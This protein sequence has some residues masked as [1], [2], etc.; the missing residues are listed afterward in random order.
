MQQNYNKTIAACFVSYIIQAVVNTFAPLLFVTFQQS[1]GIPLSFIT[2]L[3]TLNFLIQLCLDFAS[4]FFIDKIGYRA[5]LLI[6]HAF[7][8]LGLIL[9]T[10]LPEIPGMPPFAGIL[11]SVFFYAIGGGLIEV[12]VS[13]VVE[14]CPND[15]KD[16]TMS[17]LHSF[18]CWGSVAVAVVSTAFFAVFGIHNWKILSVIWAILPIVNGIIF[19]KLP[20][21]ELVPEGEK[22]L[23]LGELFRNRVFIILL[24]VI[25]CAGAC[26][27]AVGQ[28]ASAFV[29]SALG[30]SKSFGDLVGPALFAVLMGI[31]RVIYGKYGDKMDL[32]KTML[33]SSILCIIGYLTVSLSS[34]SVVS[35]IGVAVC[36]FSVGIL[37]PGTYSTASAS[38]KGGGNTMFSFLALGGDLGCASGPTLVGIAASAF[39][40]N[41]KTGIL[42]AAIFPVVLTVLMLMKLGMRK[43]T[44]Q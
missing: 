10:V 37:W 42:A 34:S 5:S 6:A 14:A 9:L 3:I 26:E 40:D 38:I 44:K 24:L 33:Y 25:T 23:S 30:I 19:I 17:L 31:S 36:G 29:E 39:G 11:I 8:A 22:K 43:K 35:L 1:Y 18:Y 20:L 7:A 12:V 2:A 28:W 13:P 4:A 16:R 27:L 32:E 41:L 21:C 15:H